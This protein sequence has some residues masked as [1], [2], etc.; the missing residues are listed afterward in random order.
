MHVLK[1]PLTTTA[2]DCQEIERRF[3]AAC[4]IHNVLV[5]HAR[6][7]LNRIRNDRE[8]QRLKDEYT[9]FLKKGG[10]KLTDDELARKKELSG[11]MAAIRKGIGLSEAGFQSYI[12]A[13][14]KQFRKRLSSQQVQKEATRVWR[15]AEKVLFS[16]GRE[17]HFK[18]YMDFLTVSGKT[19]LNGVRFNKDTLSISWLGL[20]IPCRLA[21]RGKD[22]AYQMEALDDEVSYC[23]IK[24]EMFPNGWH[25]YVS[26]VLKGTA[27]K[28]LIKTGDPSNICGIDIGV[29]TAAAVSGSAVY[30][31]ELAPGCAKYNREITKLQEHMDNSRRAT[32]PGKFNP[33]GTI[34]K[35]NRDRWVYSNTYRRNR[36][37][38]MYTYRRKAAYIRQCHEELANIL[39]A[40]SVNFLVEDM[41]F[42]GLQKRS[43]QTARQD[44]ES[45]ARQ[46]DGSVRA[47]RKYKRKKRF[48]R[49]LNNRAP[50]EFI[51]IL[52]RKAAAYGGS[53]E[54]INT[55]KF[56]ASQYDH[57]SGTY[58]KA[59]LSER[60]KEIGG[61]QVQRDLYSA[62]LISNSNGKLDA[63]DR[64]KCSYGFGKFL[65]MQ[66]AL[67]AAM[68]AGNITMKQCF[69]F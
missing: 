59:A 65:A 38:L 13:C 9:L 14:G 48:G 17:L 44:K 26:I 39:L 63:P 69:G 30:L 45:L 7:L 31:E 21:R 10:N 66:D 25:Y 28:K 49:S 68:K 51:G 60:F 56:R 61:H 18:R 42:K 54:K 11:Q 27:P 67:I 23:D 24:R 6:K 55:Q 62:F 29:S 46:K 37:L 3:H 57:V 50:A 2:S 4:H 36:R 22:R 20:D 52:A 41:S 33:D 34:K 53:L 43:K 1:L 16:D 47:V 32:N 35:G 5:K 64:D 19:N 15:G 8:Y 40:D 58:R 12:K